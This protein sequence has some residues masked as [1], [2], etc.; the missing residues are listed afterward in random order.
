MAGASAAEEGRNM[1]RVGAFGLVLLAAVPSPTP[2]DCGKPYVAFLE[3]LSLEADKLSGERL[4]GLHRGGLRIFDACD[5]G[6]MRDVSAKFAELE[7]RL[8]APS[9][10]N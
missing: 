1:K 8:A 6:H 10:A 4:A 5:A 2:V 3:K 7:V 9:S